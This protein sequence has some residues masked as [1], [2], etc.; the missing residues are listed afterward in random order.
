MEYEFDEKL[1]KSVYIVQFFDIFAFALFKI[2]LIAY[3]TFG[4][5]SMQ[6]LVI[7]VSM[8]AYLAVRNV[9]VLLKHWYESLS[10]MSEVVRLIGYSNTSNQ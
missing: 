6:E 9:A 5:G 4:K 2:L 1:S 8:L 7:P 3:Y 10:I